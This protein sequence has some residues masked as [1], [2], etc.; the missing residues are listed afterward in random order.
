MIFKLSLVCLSESSFLHSLRVLWASLVAQKVK[1]NSVDSLP[2]SSFS[3][4]FFSTLCVTDASHC[5][6]FMARAILCL[7][8]QESALVAL[9]S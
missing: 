1:K 7:M 8:G 2:D 5:V 3:C 9:P 6:M 4:V